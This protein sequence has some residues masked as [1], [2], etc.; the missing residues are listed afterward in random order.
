MKITYVKK[1]I[2]KAGRKIEYIEATVDNGEIWSIPIDLGNT[3]YQAYLA[4]L[5]QTEKK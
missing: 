5:E 2:D 4:Q 1:S 3:H